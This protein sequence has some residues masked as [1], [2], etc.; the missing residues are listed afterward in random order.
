MTNWNGSA[1]QV[2]HWSSEPTRRWFSECDA[3]EHN[4]RRR[5]LVRDYFEGYDLITKDAGWIYICSQC[6][7]EE[8]SDRLDT[9][10]GQRG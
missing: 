9:A 2:T 6:M 10:E 1:M 8:L 4:G 7:V 3:L 5:A